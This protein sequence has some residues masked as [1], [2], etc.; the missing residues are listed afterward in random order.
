VETAPNQREKAA[1]ERAW[2]LPDGCR[3][4]I[5]RLFQECGAGKW[6]LASELFE[7]A[8]GRSCAKQFAFVKIPADVEKIHDYFG[9]LHVADLGLACACAEGSEAAWNEFV[10]D[11]RG[12]L[13]TAATAILRVSSADPAAIELADSLFADLYGMGEGKTG[14]RSLFRYFYGRSSLKTWLR[15]VLAQRH[16]D[17]IRAGKKFDSLED[18]GE[19]GKSRRVPELVSAELPADPHREEYLTRFREALAAALRSLEAPDEK[20]LRLYYVEE[21]TL[22][23]I[24]GELGEHESSVSRNLERIRK[25]LRSAV[26][27]RLRAGSGVVN[28]GSTRGMDEAQMRLCIEYAAQD[29]ALDFG[30]LF[31]SRRAGTMSGPDG[32][33]AP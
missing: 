33:L 8:I 32:K 26:E 10:T 16:V 27:Q 3:P 28:G 14:G 9:T 19:D 31:G 23:E 5:A 2:R 24:G 17:M 13:R 4:A 20:R 11:Y 25:E 30:K 7:A 29:A 1:L 18:E 22:A 12:P 6:D 21:Q 15:A